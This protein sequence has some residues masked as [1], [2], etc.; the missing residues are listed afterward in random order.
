MVKHNLEEL[1]LMMKDDARGLVTTS[2][3]SAY[4]RGNS[5]W[6]RILVPLFYTVT[7]T[8]MM[9]KEWQNMDVAK[10]LHLRIK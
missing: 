8:I 10:M 6:L 1:R 4:N 2:L 7:F 9:L 3:T 5:M